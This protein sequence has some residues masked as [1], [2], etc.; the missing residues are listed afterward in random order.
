MFVTF[1]TL[2]TLPGHLF[3]IAVMTP[4]TAIM[5]DATSPP[6]HGYTFLGAFF[7]INSLTS[8][9]HFH[10]H[11]LT[12]FSLRPFYCLFLIFGFT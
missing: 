4:P 10:L 6:A 2:S 11:P 3:F 12:F 9:H 1:N 8:L 7:T 5:E